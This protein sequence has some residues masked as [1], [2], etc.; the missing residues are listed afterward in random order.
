MLLAAASG[1]REETLA[2][3]ARQI[4]ELARDLYERL[5]TMG[6]HFSRLGSRLDK[7]VEAYNETLGSLEARVLPA[8]RR[9]PDLGV[10]AKNELP[11]LAAIDRAAKPLTAPELGSAA[12]VEAA[13]SDAEAA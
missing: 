6:S 7:A 13:G 4:S 5:A 9:F 2:D 1:W 11:A 8:A 12:D 3:S 10:P